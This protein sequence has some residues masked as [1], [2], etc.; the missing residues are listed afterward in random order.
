MKNHVIPSFVRPSVAFLFLSLLL[1]CCMSLQAQVSGGTLSG[2]IMDSTGAVVPNAQVT[3]TN[4]GTGLART[5]ATNDSGFYAVP[6]L[7]PGNYQVAVEAK[8]FA[9]SAEQT[10]ITVGQQAELNL[11][12]AVAAQQSTVQV[13][14]VVPQVELATSTMSATVG[15]QA[16]RDIPLNGRDWTSLAQLEPNVHAVDTQFSIQ[17]GN[18]SR[19]NRGWGTQLMIAGNRPQQNNYRLDGVTMNDYSGSGPGSVL[20]GALGVDAIQEFSVITGNADAQYGRQSGGVINAVTRA[21]SNSLHGSVYEFLR[22]SALDTRNYFD[23]PDVPPFKRNQF[24]ASLGGP[25]DRNHT[26]FFF[27]YEG[28]RQ[29]LSTTT[30]DTVPSNNARN[31]IVCANSACTSTTKVTIDPKVAPFLALFPVANGPQ[32]GDL[33]NYSFVSNSSTDENL[34]TGRLDH[35]FSDRDSINGTV[36]SDNS[37]NSQPDTYDFTLLGMVVNRKLISAQENHIFGPSLANFARIGYSRTVSLAPESAGAVNPLANDTS[38]GFAPNS[39]VGEMRISGVTIFPGGVNAEGNYAYHYNSYQ[40]YDD[41]FWTHGAHSIKFGGAFEHDQSNEFGST[42]TG[43][44]V[45]GSLKNFLTNSPSSF[46]SAVPGATTPIYLRQSVGGAYVQDDWHVRHNLTLNLGIR[47]EIASVPTEAFNH[48]STLPSLTATQPK[49]GSPYF[50]NPTKRDFSPRVGFSWDPFGD[51]KTAVRSGFGVYDT[52]PLIYEFELLSLNVAPYALNVSLPKAPKG[53]FPSGAYALATAVANTGLRYAY[54]QQNPGRSY[55]M[56]WNFSVQRQLPGQN[57]VEVGYIG[58]HGVHQPF[59]A[60]DSNMVLPADPQNLIW[61]VS[62]GT[63]INPAVGN[64][65][66][67]AWNVSSLYDAATARFTRQQKG[68]RYGVSYTFA[69]SLDETSGSVGGSTYVN[70]ITSPFLLF[71]NRFKGPSD[72]DVRQNFVAN[73]LWQLPGP[74]NGFAGKIV[75]GWELGTIFSVRSGLPFTALIGGDPLGLQDNNP[76]SF[77]DQVSGCN[78]ITGNPAHYIN[79]ACFKFPTDSAGNPQPNRL[80]DVGRNSLTGPG[81]TDWDL[82]FIKNTRI[83]EQFNL[84]FRAEAFNLLNQANF[85]TPDRVTAQIFNTVTDPKTGEI[86]GALIPTAGQLK[87]TSTSSRQLQFALKV[88]F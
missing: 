25:I 33:G 60:N 4:L 83:T 3:V 79:T 80:G 45:F 56:Q 55:V 35:T 44:F 58:S 40:A 31:G 48:L 62:G 86:T 42:T 2:T 71:A 59:R 18:N 17:A 67:L 11:H 57:T 41:L 13:Q 46:T 37:S 65:D 6:N 15:G 43:S 51:G 22:N 72:F 81:L 49:I 1:F 70:S 61:P 29:E 10:L 73:A 5:T 68:V 24:G 85:A 23:G 14:E 39:T 19:A 32:T 82:S 77:P 88:L 21:G 78:P 47:Y 8:G 53:S 69:K 76:F 27:D 16:V 74:I 52:L 84:Q 36:L 9:R 38:L 75:G 28:L 66:T 64:I 26:F 20:G 34:F 63:K 54:V 50:N 12:V 30:L 87:A 7:N